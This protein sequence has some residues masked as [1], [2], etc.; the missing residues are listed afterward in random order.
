MEAAG[1]VPA[2]AGRRGQ[3]GTPT[4]RCSGCWSSPPPRWCRGWPRTTDELD[5]VLHALDG[6]FVPAGPSGSPLRGLVNVL[7]TGRNFYTVDP[8]GGP[9]AAG[10]GDRRRRWPTRWSQ[11][12]LDETGELPARRSGCRSGARRRCAPPATTSPRCSRCSASARCGTRRRAGSATCD[13]VPLDELGRPRIDV[14]VRISGFFRDAFPHVVAMLDDAVRLV[15]ELDEPRRAELRAGPRAGRPGRARR[16]AAGHH[17][18]LRLQ[19]R[20]VRRRHP[21]ADRVRATGATTT[22]SPRSTRRGAASPTAASSTERRPRD[23]MEANYRRI[24]VAAKNID[25]REHDIAD[26]DDYFQYHGGMVAT[27]RALTGTD[28]KAYVGDSTTP[29][30]VRTRSLHGGDHP[31]LPGPGGQPALDRARCSGTATRARSSSPRPSTTCS[32]STPPP[33]W[34]TTGCTTRSPGRTCSTRRTRSSCGT[35]NPWA[36]RGIIEK[37]HEAADRGLWAEPDPEVDGRDAAGL[38]RRRGRP[39]GPRVTAACRDPRRR[40]G[41][42][43][44]VTPEVARGAARRSTTCSPPQKS[45]QDGPLLEARARSAGCTE[46]SPLVAVPDPERD[47]DAPRDYPRAV[48]RLARG[49]GGGVRAGA[50]STGPATSAFLVWGDPSL[51]DS[52]IRIVESIRRGAG[53]TLEYDVLPGHQRAC[54]CSPPATGSCCTRSAGRCTSPPVAGCGRR[55]TQGQDNI[56]VMLNR[57]R[58]TSTGSRTGTIWWGANLGTPDEALVAGRVGDVARRH[59]RGPRAR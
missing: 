5:A 29:D 48:A 54:S 44:H 40:D 56:V 28:P 27:V 9:V 35:S 20:V 4:P 11:R 55:S 36:L 10:L 6:G 12:Y 30:A 31:G 50:R 58:S 45:A 26:S 37:L 2:T 14:T 33:A 3:L 24:T 21:A 25:T 43:Q 15:A 7:P 13:V 17:P 22:T 34:C 38:P 16:R 32:A 8:Q 51:Y 53:S 1:L 47:R 18:D 59:R 19:A 46:T 39:G 23:D 41:D 52:T 42:P 49:A 57:E